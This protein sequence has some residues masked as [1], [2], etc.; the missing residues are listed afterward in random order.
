MADG[1]FNALAARYD[2]LW[3]RSTIGRLQREAVWRRLDTLFRPGDSLLDLGCGPGDDALHF[4][5]SGMRVRA[6]DSSSEM[7]RIA[8]GR[9]VDATRLAIEELRGLK[10][11]FDGAISNFGPL[12]CIRSLDRIRGP[13]ARLIRPGGYLALCLM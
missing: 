5:H 9:G 12:N 8:R 13:L 2:E 3:S 11:V 6:I 1:A 7:V 4:M 10:G